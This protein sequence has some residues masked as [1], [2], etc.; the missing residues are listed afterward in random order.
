VRA[1]ER[2]SKVIFKKKE[3]DKED[4]LISAFFIHSR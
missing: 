2:K 3:E 1:Y 4:E